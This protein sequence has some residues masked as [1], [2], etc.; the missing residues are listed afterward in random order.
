ML[1]LASRGAEADSPP[2]VTVQGHS[3]V[4]R[5]IDAQGVERFRDKNPVVGIF[6]NQLFQ[7]GIVLRRPHEV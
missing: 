1:F 3:L 5:C 7:G 6:L 4:D 2:F